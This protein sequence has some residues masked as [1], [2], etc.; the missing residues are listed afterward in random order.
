MVKSCFSG[1][2]FYCISWLSNVSRPHMVKLLK[3]ESAIL[4][5]T[6]LKTICA[7]TAWIIRIKTTDILQLFSIAIHPTT[8]KTIITITAAYIS[9]IS[10]VFIV[11]IYAI[12][13]SLTFKINT[14]EI[15]KWG[16]DVATRAGSIASG[17][18]LKTDISLRY[19]ECQCLQKKLNVFSVHFLYFISLCGR[20]IKESFDGLYSEWPDRAGWFL[21]YPV[22]KLMSIILRWQGNEPLPSGFHI[23]WWWY[24]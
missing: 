6:Q 19:I 23:Q 18:I 7:M 13:I 2:L 21:N 24:A 16:V 9:I 1:Q 3:T 20:Y 14:T 8:E 10:N 12:R 11:I 15:A 5:N 22:N 4:W 17:G